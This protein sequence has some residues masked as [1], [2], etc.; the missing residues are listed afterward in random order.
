[1]REYDAKFSDGKVLIK[2]RPPL[3]VLLTVYKWFDISPVR[4]GRFCVPVGGVT[5]RLNPI[6]LCPTLQQFPYL[7]RPFLTGY[8][9]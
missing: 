8:T 5:K 2:V 4:G 3:S 9:I 7:E 1:M 6:L